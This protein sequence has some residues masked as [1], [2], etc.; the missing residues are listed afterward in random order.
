MTAQESPLE[1]RWLQWVRGWFQGNKVPSVQQGERAR[2]RREARVAREEPLAL[3]AEG[4]LVGEE[5]A[6][7]EEGRRGFGTG[8]CC[9]VS[10]YL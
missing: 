1:S 8:L 9:L 6:V 5:D 10:I 3:G 7:W 2:A 4:F